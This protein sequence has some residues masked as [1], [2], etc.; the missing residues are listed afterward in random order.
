M[1]TI[2]VTP[3]EST[4]IPTFPDGLYRLKVTNPHLDYSRGSGSSVIGCMLNVVQG[5]YAGQAIPQ[6]YSLQQEDVSKN[7]PDATWRW[8]Q[9]VRA[10]GRLTKEM[11]AEETAFDIDDAQMVELLKDMEGWAELFNEPYPVGGPLRTKL[12]AFISEDE[13]KKRSELPK[14]SVRVGTAPVAGASTIAA[15]KKPF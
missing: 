7:A 1:T 11:I 3:K 14:P 9:D 2:H 10:T 13:Y 4:S 8:K 15:A 6:Q 5:D 12:R